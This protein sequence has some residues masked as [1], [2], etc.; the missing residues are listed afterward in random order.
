MPRDQE[1]LARI[2]HY[3]HNS[4][5]TRE[6]SGPVYDAIRDECPV[7]H[8]DSY[9]GFWVVVEYETLRQVARDSETFCSR[10][11]SMI[12]PLGVNCRL[13]PMES[14]PPDHARF[15]DLLVPMLSPVRVKQFEPLVREVARERLTRLIR[16]GHA[17][18]NEDFAKQIPMHVITRVLG[19]ERSQKFWDWTETLVY[20]RLEPDSTDRIV[21]ASS[22][23]LAFFEALLAERRRAGQHRDDVIGALLDAEQDGRINPSETRDLC[24]FLLGAGLDNTALAIRAAI[25]HLAAHPGDRNR[26]LGDPELVKR[27]VE[28]VLRLY[29]P[30]PGLSR[31][32]TSTTEL[33]GRRLVAGE[34]VLLAFGAANRDRGAFEHPE[35]FRLDRRANPHVAFGVGPH[36]CIGL[37]LARLEIRVAI[38]EMLALTPDVCLERADETSWFPPHEL[39]VSSP[40][41]SGR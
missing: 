2:N 25:W 27:A 35:A 33:G 39:L 3:D 12:P 1:L 23:L 11:G 13:L 22:Q 34:R 21:E 17:D 16:A 8:S 9:G 4:I 36:R 15:R 32:V 40:T 6:P 29:A 31:T 20:G 18:L 14:D 28:E 5:E 24:F 10:Y 41:G 38:E 30:V 26:L 37:H 7:F 19:I